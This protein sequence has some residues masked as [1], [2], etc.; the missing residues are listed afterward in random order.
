MNLK[1]T[2]EHA[3]YNQFI[4]TWRR[5]SQVSGDALFQELVQKYSEPHRHYHNLSHIASCLEEAKK[6][7]LTEKSQVLIEL[8]IWFHDAIYDLKSKNN[9]R[10]SAEFF[11]QIASQSE[12]DPIITQ[13]VCKMILATEKHE[14]PEGIEIPE[15]KTFLDIDLS[16]LGSNAERFQK[17]NEDIRQEYSWVPSILYHFKRKQILRAF[18]DR[19]ELYFTPEFKAKYE[20]QARKNLLS[21]LR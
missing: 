17:Y 10:K 21:A 16:I 6:L 20:T 14:L 5:V 9:E 8:A 13:K 12:I 1:N 19:E 18:L 4:T 7:G 15:L 3:L 11:R 2:S